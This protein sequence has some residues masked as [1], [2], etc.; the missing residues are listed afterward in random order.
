MPSETNLSI[1]MTQPPQQSLLCP[2]GAYAHSEEMVCP[3]CDN[4]KVWTEVKTSTT[5]SGLLWYLIC[6]CCCCPMA[7][8]PFFSTDFKTTIHFCP[9]CGAKLAINDPP[10]NH[11]ATEWTIFAII[12]GSIM[13]VFCLFILISSRYIG[14]W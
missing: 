7:I 13:L 10:A 1:D 3:S 8:L 4:L 9:H 14:L 12:L 5:A 11:R 2:V 6:G